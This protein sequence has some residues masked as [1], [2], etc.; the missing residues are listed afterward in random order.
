MKKL[1][2]LTALLFA[3][4]SKAQIGFQVEYSP[5][6]AVLN[7][8][9]FMIEANYLTGGVIKWGGMLQTDHS[10]D[11]LLIG[12]KAECLIFEPTSETAFSLLLSWAF[13]IEETQENAFSDPHQR[14]YIQAGFS[15]AF[16]LTDKYTLKLAPSKRYWG[17]SENFVF[18]I[19]GTV[20]LGN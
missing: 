19:G 10:F 5:Q 17:D 7:S 9:E 8:D 14:H 12:A 6:Y 4:E 16:N 18:S 13:D 3:L 11:F 1:F 15:Y 2:L 20:R